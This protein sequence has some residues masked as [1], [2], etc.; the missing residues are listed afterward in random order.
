VINTAISFGVA[1]LLAALLFIL[2]MP[3]WVGAPVGL[4][5]GVASFLFVGKRVRDELESTFMQAHEQLKR[6][7]WEPAIRTMQ[8]G[9][10]LSSWQFLVKG[11]IDGQIGMV[12]YLRNKHA[13]AEPLLKSA[14]MNHYIAKA[15]LAILQWKRRE[16]KL[17]KETLDLAIRSGR[18]ESILYALYAYLLNEMKD[19]EAAVEVIN[20]GLKFCKD[21]ERLLANRTLLQ[22]KKPMKMKLYGEQWYQFMI[23]R[24]VMRVE[25]PPYAR[26]SKRQA[27]G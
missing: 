7:Q 17:A 3:P 15:M 21:D 5:G 13:E 25:P 19:R 2:H 22:N 10:R 4:A 12:Q 8:S 11:S 26:I 16:T 18:K 1:I 23:E 27:R 6:Q 20:R 24:P 9:Y 14:S